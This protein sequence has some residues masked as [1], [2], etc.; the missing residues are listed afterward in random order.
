MKNDSIFIVAII[1][2]LVFIGGKEKEMEK[3]KRP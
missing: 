1:K 2:L 3:A